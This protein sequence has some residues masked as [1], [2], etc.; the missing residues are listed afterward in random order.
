L[1]ETSSTV[2]SSSSSPEQMLSSR[3]IWRLPIR[4]QQRQVDLGRSGSGGAP[5]TWSGG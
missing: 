3:P 1:W 2:T 4:N 5:S